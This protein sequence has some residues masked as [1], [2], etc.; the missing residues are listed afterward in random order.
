MIRRTEIRTKLS[1]ND[2]FGAQ[3][4][5]QIKGF[6]QQFLLHFSLYRMEGPLYP[7]LASSNAVRHHVQCG[8]VSAEFLAIDVPAPESD[9]SGFS[10]ST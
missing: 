1:K 2:R 3:R 4:Q 6:Q 8:P 5:A 9:A 7:P 10:L